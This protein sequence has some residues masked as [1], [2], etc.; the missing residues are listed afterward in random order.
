LVSLNKQVKK[1]GGK[2]LK[3]N[4]L[5]AGRMSK[6][7][8]LFFQW[9]AIALQWLRYNSRWKKSPQARPP[10]F[11]WGNRA[12]GKTLVARIIH[13]LSTRAKFP[14]VKINCAALPENLLESELFGHEKGAFTGAA[15]TKA[16]RLE[17]AHGGTVFSG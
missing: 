1:T 11:C 2:L 16:G 7:G 14:F 5:P 17:E 12:R 15:R 6:R 13:E 3:Q 4:S 8:R 9:S 10:S